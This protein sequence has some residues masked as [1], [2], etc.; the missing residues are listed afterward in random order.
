MWRFA[1]DVSNL[2]LSQIIN[3]NP[4]IFTPL[5]PRSV[6]SAG[7]LAYRWSCGEILLEPTKGT[8][9]DL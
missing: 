9:Q 4:I 6:G 2:I 5:A 8:S 3:C 1:Q 7:W